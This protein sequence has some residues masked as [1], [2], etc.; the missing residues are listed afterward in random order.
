MSKF[1]IGYN[2]KAY[3]SIGATI[4]IENIKTFNSRFDTIY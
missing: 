2:P 4:N 3:S 1:A